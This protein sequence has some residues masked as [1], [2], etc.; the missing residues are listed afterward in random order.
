MHLWAQNVIADPAGGI[1]GQLLCGL[2][3]PR[4]GGGLTGLLQTLTDTLNGLLG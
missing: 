1:L 2:V 3:G 4:R